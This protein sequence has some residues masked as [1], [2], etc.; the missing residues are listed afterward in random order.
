[1]TKKNQSKRLTN[2]HKES[3]GVVGIF[4]DEAKSHDITVGKISLFVIEQLEKEFP[5]LSF[6]YKTSIKKEEINEALK[7]IDPELGQTLFVSNSSI[8]PDGGIIEVKDDNGNWRIVLVSEAKHQGKDIENIKAGK[9]VGAK[10]DQDLMAAGNAIERSHKNISEIANLMLS[11]SHFPY[12]LFLEGSNFLTE[13]IS[14]KRPD[15]RV[16]TLEYNSGTLNRLDRLTS[17]NYGMPINTNLCKNKFV[18]H[19]DKTIMLQAT[20]IYTQGNGEKW[21]VKK[22]FDIMLEISKTSL[23]VLGSEIFNQITKSK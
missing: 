11:E 6:Q 8:I 21:D 19:K 15:G 7:K 20:S 10:N 3:K 2:Q 9:L 13:T 22:M 5:Q 23:K 18:K 14:I 16:V 12:V 4:G 17:A 1:M